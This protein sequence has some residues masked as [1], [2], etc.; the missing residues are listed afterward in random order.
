MFYK[1]V[2]ND[3]KMLRWTVRAGE[4]FKRRGKK[5]LKYFMPITLLG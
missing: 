2:I 1:K 4:A 3:Q 5:G